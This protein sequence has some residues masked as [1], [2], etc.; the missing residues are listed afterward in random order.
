M[1]PIKKI[2]KHFMAINIGQKYFMTPAPT[3]FMYG[4]EVAH[5]FRNE[6]IFKIY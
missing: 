1:W 4:P 3:Y 5:E 2:Q 6:P